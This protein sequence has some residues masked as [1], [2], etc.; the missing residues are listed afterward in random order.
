[1]THRAY[2]RAT[3]VCFWTLIAAALLFERVGDYSGFLGWLA[4][5]AVLV[6]MTLHFYTLWQRA[7]EENEETTEPQTVPPQ[8]EMENSVPP[9]S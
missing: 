4:V 2:K 6:A 7:K 3:S 9:L 1:M 8:L 5:A